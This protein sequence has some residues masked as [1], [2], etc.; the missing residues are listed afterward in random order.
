MG[1]DP[2]P[3]PPVTPTS[4]RGIG[5]ALA[6]TVIGFLVAVAPTGIGLFLLPVAPLPLAARHGH[7]RSRALQVIV[8]AVVGIAAATAVSTFTPTGRIAAACLAVLLTIIFP[9]VVMPRFTSEP[10]RQIAFVALMA[11]YFVAVISPLLADGLLTHPHRAGRAAAQRV[12]KEYFGPI[13]RRCDDTGLSDTEWALRSCDNLTYQKPVR[14]LL[15]HQLPSLAAAG[16]GILALLMA[17]VGHRQLRRVSGRSGGIPVPSVAEFTVHWSTS[18]LLA[19]SVAAVWIGGRVGGESGALISGVGVGIAATIGLALT[20][21]GGAVVI[22]AMRRFNVR[23]WL[24]VAIWILLLMSATGVIL[25][26]CIGLIEQGARLR[27]RET[28]RMNGRSGDDGT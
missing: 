10:R 9:M 28:R 6:A 12:D 26:G 16:A 24:R 23:I 5:G 8:A 1:D 19:A 20:L 27:D 17:L 15:R 25:I 7:G 3:T 13:E 4:P 2:Q 11:I 14:R 22:W 21:Q 18:Y